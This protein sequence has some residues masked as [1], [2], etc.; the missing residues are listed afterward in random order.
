MGR[1]WGA[2]G[3]G[4]PEE[5]RFWVLQGGCG[6]PPQKKNILTGW[7]QRGPGTPPRGAPRS[8]L[9]YSRA[10]MGGSGGVP[11]P[12]PRAGPL[13]KQGLPHGGG[14]H[15][16]PLG[17]G[18]GMPGCHAPHRTAAWP[19]A[20]CRGSFWESSWGSS[21]GSPAP[22]GDPG[23]ACPHPLLS[24][25]ESG[26]WWPRAPGPH[27][28][29]CGVSLPVG[30]PSP[31]QTD[32]GTLRVPAQ[33]PQ[34]PTNAW[35]SP[36]KPKQ[37]PPRSLGGTGHFYRAPFC[38]Q[39]PHKPLPTLRAPG[40]TQAVLGPAG[41]AQPCPSSGSRPSTTAPLG[42]PQLFW[43]SS[44]RPLGH[45]ARCRGW[46]SLRCPHPVPTRAPRGAA[47]PGLGY[48]WGR[49]REPPTEGR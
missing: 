14:A 41:G 23:R 45:T 19:A 12:Q 30:W 46:P 20:A 49:T 1:A 39:S 22:G 6:D 18:K 33:S 31:G 37:P 43:E 47:S 35:G 40:T 4:W 8:R 17:G 5:S 25:A 34:A 11:A 48:G 13:P 27:R 7:G 36:P 10:A 44:K 9:P 3:A 24:A 32:R 16:F 21:W 42:S 29:P 15:P 2:Q 26:V 38:P 28:S